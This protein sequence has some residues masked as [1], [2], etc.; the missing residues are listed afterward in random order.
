[1]FTRLRILSYYFGYLPRLFTTINRIHKELQ[2][3]F[4]DERM[5]VSG[6]QKLNHPKVKHRVTQYALIHVV[7]NESIARYL[8][9]SLN[10]SEFKATLFACAS[11]PFFDDFFDEHNY[12]ESEIFQLLQECQ[13]NF[14]P[15]HSSSKKLNNHSHP[16]NQITNSTHSENPQSDVHAYQY[17]LG[18]VYQNVSDKNRFYSYFHQLYQSQWDSKQLSNPSIPSDKAIK[19]SRNKGGYSALVFRSLIDNPITEIESEMLFQLGVVGQFMDDIFDLYDDYQKGIQSLAHHFQGDID[20]MF[21]AFKHEV[22][23]LY[24]CI[25]KT[26]IPRKSKN[27]FRWEIQLIIAAGYLACEHFLKIQ[28]GPK[29]RIDLNNMDRK[30]MIIDMEKWSN[31]FKMLYISCFTNFY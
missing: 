19:I 17:L 6:L 10:K 24:E 8:G 9:K 28:H 20:S 7:L 2:A 26:N 29:G 5:P 23:N 13:S 3:V 18:L 15:H 21:K 4:Q 31:Q 16:F 1:M 11:G 14:Q 22:R 12:S 27:H 25:D 30:A